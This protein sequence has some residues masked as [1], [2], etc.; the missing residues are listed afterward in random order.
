MKIQFWAGTG[1]A[2]LF[3]QT[4]EGDG[5]WKDAHFLAQSDECGADWL[6]VSDDPHGPLITRVPPQRRILFT[7]EP[8]VVKRYHAHYA[9]QFGFLVSPMRVPGFRGKWIQ[10]HGA[11]PWMFSHENLHQS[12]SSTTPEKSHDLSVICSHARKYSD[13]RRR[14]EFVSQLKHLLGDRLHWYGKGIQPIKHKAEAILPYK[15]SI[16]IENNYIEHFW[17]EKIADIYLGYAFPFYS[18]GKNIDRYFNPSSFC[19][20]DIDDAQRSAET[21][22]QTLEQNLYESRNTVLSE[23]RVKVLNEYNFFNEAWKMVSTFHQERKDV[24]QLAKE[25]YIKTNRSGMRSVVSK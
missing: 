1:S 5:V 21:I 23:A 3:R 19:Y 11:L 12:S 9:N 20:L 25:Q 13:H 17:T 7:T 16:A 14:Y 24:P 15:Y 4:P 22:L 2:S 8:P 6:V 18:G 10:R